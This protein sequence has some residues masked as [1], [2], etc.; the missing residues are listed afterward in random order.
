MSYQK[1]GL[2]NVPDQSFNRKI[3]ACAGEIILSLITHLTGLFQQTSYSKNSVTD[4]LTNVAKY[5]TNC[6][7]CIVYFPEDNNLTSLNQ[8]PIAID[9][10][11]FHGL[12]A[13][14]KIPQIINQ[15]S[16]SSLLKSFEVS[17]LPSSFTV[18]NL[19]SIPI[20]KNSKSLF[21]LIFLYNKYDSNKKISN[22]T[23]N[24][25][26]L[27][28][29]AGNLVQEIVEIQN[30]L[31]QTL[32]DLRIAQKVYKEA[33][34]LQSFSANL[35]RREK[36]FEHFKAN[37]KG[38]DRK[39]LELLAITLDASG[40]LVHIKQGNSM[41]TVLTHG[42]Q[43][44]IVQF[45][46]TSE[47]TANVIKD[48]WTVHD[49]NSEPLWCQ[50]LLEYRSLMSCP[51][52]SPKG[53]T[54]GVIEF[55]RIESSFTEQDQRIG[56]EILKVLGNIPYQDYLKLT[57]KGKQGDGVEKS[58]SFV[59]EKFL[60][61]EMLIDKVR[62]SLMILVPNENCSFHLI[63]QKFSEHWTISSGFVQKNQLAEDSIVGFSYFNRK[64]ILSCPNVKLPI[65][66]I[67]Y[68]KGKHIL[69]V[70]V[71]NT[72]FEYPVVG[73][74]HL[75]RSKFFTNKDQELVEKIANTLSYILENLYVIVSSP[76]ASKN[77]NLMPEEPRISQVHIEKTSKPTPA[78]QFLY[79][80]DSLSAEKLLKISSMR[81]ILENA[82]NP[83]VSFASGIATLLGCKTGG[84]LIKNVTEDYCLYLPKG[85]LVSLGGLIQ[86]C[87]LK[88]STIYIKKNPQEVPEFDQR[89]DNLD[90][91]EP[92]SNILC[93][94]IPNFKD[95]VSA[96]ICLLNSSTGFNIEDIVLVQYFAVTAREL[97]N[98]KNPE[99][100]V[101]QVILNETRKYK[102]LLRWFKQ[103]FI[104]SNS[105]KS[106][107]ELSKNVFQKVLADSN[108]D[109][110]ISCL[111]QVLKAITNSE[112]GFALYCSE[113]KLVKYKTDSS[114]QTEELSG[115]NLE[116]IQM[117]TPSVLSK[118]GGRENLFV[119]PYGKFPKRLALVLGN[120][121]D[122]TL[123]YFCVYN[124]ADEAMVSE[125]AR[126]IYNSL[127]FESKESHSELKLTIRRY[128]AGMNTTSLINTIRSGAQ[129][130]LE[131]ERA[132]VF[133][134]ENDFLVVK[135][136]GIEHEIPVG[137]KV[138]ITKG[139]VGFVAQT[140]QSENIEDVYKDPRF[141]SDID[142]M[143]G[144]RT[145]SM[146]CMPVFDSNNHVIAALQMINKRSGT[147]T[148]ND[149]ENLELFAEMSSTVLQNW[150]MIEK[151]IEERS[152]YLNILNSIG[153]Y[154]I[155]LNSEG[156]LQYINK[157]IATLFGTSEQISKSTHYSSWLRFNRQL[158]IDIT[159]VFKNPE[160][161]I[162]RSCQ[163]MSNQR[164]SNSF[165]DIKF[166]ENAN[167]FNYTVCSLNDS[168]SCMAAGA[169]IILEDASTIEELNAKYNQIQ[170]QLMKL[171]NPVQ[172]ETSLQRCIN[173]LGV[174]QRSLDE[175]GQICSLIQDIIDT[176]RQGNLQ[177]TE[178]YIPIELKSIEKEIK[179]RLSLYLEDKTLRPRDVSRVSYS[180]PFANEFCA[181][182][183]GLEC[184]NNWSLDAF[185][186]SDHF[187]YIR[188]MFLKFSLL[189]E[190]QI[191]PETFQQFLYKVRLNYLN[192]AFHNFFH[193]FSVLHSAYFLLNLPKINE[194]FNNQEIFSILVAALCHDLGHRGY[195][196][197]YESN[198]SSE[199]ALTYNDISILE[200]YHTSLTFKLINENDSNIFKNISKDTVRYVRKIIIECILSTDMMKHFPLIGT[201]TDRFKQISQNPIGSLDQD[202]VHLSG[203]IVHC[204]DIGHPTKVL[205]VYKKWSKLVCEEFSNQYTQEIAN[206]L[207]PTEFMK[208]L[209]NPS[210][211]YKN[212]I[213][214][215]SIIVKPLWECFTL[216]ASS[217]I[218]ECMNNLNENIRH[219]QDKQNKVLNP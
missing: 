1:Q 87:F 107:H 184:L 63:N 163:R 9:T 102:I 113:D 150:M 23:M 18:H 32:E 104:V 75:C 121:R 208:G 14:K 176:L 117:T 68:Y 211:Y 98:S 207:P 27:L 35:I 83:L 76:G 13:T 130:L 60:D 148:K 187:K 126:V 144:F 135:A 115:E 16:N 125:L 109:I 152:I 198:I 205:K 114:P 61:S 40:I 161:K 177:R 146:L 154:I 183:L 46:Q 71:I 179:S 82:E 92:V 181:E 41:S 25:I 4:N 156:K 204:C 153:N 108:L 123:S 67:S 137:I 37:C 12:I 86:Q 112:E 100:S 216:W 81:K 189:S 214:F 165:Q 175:D 159:T 138:P 142:L 72:W 66:E 64:S 36:C 3:P 219:Y 218:D 59:E 124:R 95:E 93:V 188:L 97:I 7:E 34:Y 88:N 69:V 48:I 55:L 19:C 182:D 50:R 141:N 11:S 116:F 133:L 10:S 122:E 65:K 57:D 91:N 74:I 52:T 20:Q 56:K 194:I 132:T 136:Q 170:S 30:K 215:L 90:L 119:Y 195:T 129:Q 212:E 206:N 42:V 210:S 180:M 171:T 172:T 101:N 96:V 160:K 167:V 73:V 53:V 26:H 120:K 2:N 111:L 99:A 51:I 139:I 106:K 203:F 33:T 201:H 49:L 162:L 17:H 192:N 149:E 43:Q 166:V 6:F 168:T 140:G 128:A 157:Q 15:V 21:A 197:L 58:F 202:C 5:L 213:G 143:T 217:S 54:M 38:I 22:F 47:H 84:L 196:N 209:S 31:S 127:V 39:T 28:Q 200:N 169:I 164:L 105:L 155:V 131:C 191:L 62:N 118:Q 29:A 70:P 94:P 134:R 145:R 190:F 186:V 178:V 110:L 147:F 151:I 44:K 193:G 199:L 174:V 85:S 89:I 79:Q 24:D 103:V 77:F 80:I 78:L 173:Q 158:V 8:D 185:E 45:T